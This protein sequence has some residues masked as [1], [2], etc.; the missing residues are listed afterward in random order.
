MSLDLS[1]GRLAPPDSVDAVTPIIASPPRV[2]APPEEVSACVPPFDMIHGMCA[3]DKVDESLD[4]SPN[5][6]APHRA[7]TWPYPSREFSTG[8]G[9][10]DYTAIYD[11]V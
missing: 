6:F 1:S 9:L 2:S 3:K 10:A 4:I 7:R 8:E 11:I 5:A